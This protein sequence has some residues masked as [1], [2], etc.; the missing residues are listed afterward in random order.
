MDIEKKIVEITRPTIEKIGYNLVRVEWKDK[1]LCFYIDKADGVDLNDCE[2]VTKAI[3]T[4]VEDNDKA[5]GENYSLSVSS[6]G[7][8]GKS[9]S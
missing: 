5:L 3:E 6:V 9:W 4:I 7:I 8:D 1:E 2:K